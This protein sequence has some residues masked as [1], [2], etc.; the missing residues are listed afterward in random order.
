MH[1]PYSFHSM[2]KQYREEALRDARTQ[3][4]EGWLRANRRARSKRSRVGLAWGRVLSLLH[5]AVPS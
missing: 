1:S 3:H 5:V 2:S 4:L